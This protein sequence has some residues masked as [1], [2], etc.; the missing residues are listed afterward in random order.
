MQAHCAGVEFQT[1][2]RSDLRVVRFDKLI[3]H[4]TN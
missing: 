3:E 4:Q 2:L 1:G